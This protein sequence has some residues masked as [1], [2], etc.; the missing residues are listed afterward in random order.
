M[1]CVCIQYIAA[2]RNLHKNN[3]VPER[4]IHITFVPD[5]EIGG[6]DGMQIL[7]A[8]EWFKTIKVGIALDEGLA[9]EGDEYT[10]F[11]GER[12]PW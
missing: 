3:F 8:S 11:Y 5:E 1:K 12:L 6:A 10:I 4:T 9:N 2:L 7:L